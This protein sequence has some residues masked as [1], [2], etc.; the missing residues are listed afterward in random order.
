MG[1]K[2]EEELLGSTCQAKG[3]GWDQHSGCR[4]RAKGK[5]LSYSE[6]KSDRVTLNWTQEAKEKEHPCNSK[7][8]VYGS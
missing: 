1:W 7:S 3:D 5:G 8:T 4:G 6:G 2:G